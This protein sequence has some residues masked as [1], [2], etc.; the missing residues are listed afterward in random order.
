MK[1]KA[2]SN[3]IDTTANASNGAMSQEDA[4]KMLSKMSDS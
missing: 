2:E 1:L 3:V 4:I